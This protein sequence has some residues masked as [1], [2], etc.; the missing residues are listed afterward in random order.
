MRN[1]RRTSTG[2]PAA[3]IALASLSVSLSGQSRT[4]GKKWTPSKTSWGDPDIQGQ[5][6]SQTSTPLERPL[7]GE[8]AG[9]EELSDEEAETLENKERASFDAPPSAG[10]PGTY[11]AFWRDEGKGLKRTSLIID[12]PDGRVPALTPEAEKRVAAERAA[13]KG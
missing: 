11:N 2:R 5:W 6:N 9:K 1:A 7:T 3:G 12:P 13:R 8:R 10:D 4:A